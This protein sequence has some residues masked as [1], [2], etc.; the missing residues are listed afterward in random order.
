[1]TV[2]PGRVAQ[3]EKFPLVDDEL[4]QTS[5]SLVT[6]C[7]LKDFILLKSDTFYV[8]INGNK[9]QFSIEKILQRSVILAIFKVY[10]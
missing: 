6:S 8:K 4:A 5:A 10:V 9:F 2:G 7:K 3:C 1:M